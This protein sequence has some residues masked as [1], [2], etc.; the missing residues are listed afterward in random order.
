MSVIRTTIVTTTGVA[1]LA[2]VSL[3]RLTCGVVVDRVDSR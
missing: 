2:T 1:Y 3:L